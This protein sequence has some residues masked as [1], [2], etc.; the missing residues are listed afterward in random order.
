MNFLKLC[1]LASVSVIVGVM[2]AG[3]S[4]PAQALSFVKKNLPVVHVFGSELSV[5]RFQQGEFRNRGNGQWDE[6]SSKTQQVV[7]RFIAQ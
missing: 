3:L 1:K 7:Y 6:I 5:V 4:A 2:G